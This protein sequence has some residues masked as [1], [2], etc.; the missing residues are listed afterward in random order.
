MTLLT[1]LARRAFL[2][3]VAVTLATP[4]A[5]CARSPGGNMI[6]VHKTPTCAC[7]DGWVSHLRDA[8]FDVNVTITPDL[9]ALRRR[10]GVPDTL[11]SCHSGLI[12]GYFIEGHVPAGDVRRLIAQRP[13]AIGLSVPGMPLGSPGMETPGNHRDRYDTLLILRDGKIRVFT[14][15]NA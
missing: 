9:A 12:D 4:M 15:H 2:G 1:S 3:G 6:A 7:C 14:R 13:D 11:A 10:H 5:A 8:G